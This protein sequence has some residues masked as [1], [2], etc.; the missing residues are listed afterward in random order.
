MHHFARKY[1]DYNYLNIVMFQ[2]QTILIGGI[3]Q[4]LK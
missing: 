1:I 3:C 4:I 2:E